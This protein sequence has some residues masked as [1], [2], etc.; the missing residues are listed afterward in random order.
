LSFALK[1]GGALYLDEYVG[2]SRYEWKH[3]DLQL[4][5]ALLDLLPASARE[6]ATMQLPIQEDDPSE[7]VR[8]SEIQTFVNQ[9]FE[10][11]A[12]RPYGGQVVDLLFPYLDPDWTRSPEGLQAIERLLR[13]EDWDLM[14][15]PNSSHHAVAFGT[16]RPLHQISR[17]LA[18]Q[19]IAALQRRFRT[20]K[21][22]L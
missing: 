3:E 5:Q 13:I 19:G 9:F 12:W 7:A 2:P 11:I 15:R 4:A 6:P 22:R 14:S 18:S 21:V 16:L 10:V 8:S 1:R 20:L 17:P